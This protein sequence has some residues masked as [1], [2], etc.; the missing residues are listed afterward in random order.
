ML[1][2][3]SILITDGTGSSGKKGTKTIFKRFKSI[4]RH[5]ELKQFEME[6]EFSIS[7]H[8]CTQFFIGDIRD[9]ERM[10]RVFHGVDYIIDSGDKLWMLTQEEMGEIIKSLE[11]L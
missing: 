7:K 10:F 4:F 3:K 2:N 9:K 6:Q 5:Y 1:N 11:V 8:N